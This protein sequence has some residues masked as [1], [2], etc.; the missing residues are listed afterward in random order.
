VDKALLDIDAKLDSIR[1]WDEINLHYRYISEDEVTVAGVHPKS[2]GSD[3]W[4][5]HYI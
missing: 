3:F 2:Q 1:T 4:H 5:N